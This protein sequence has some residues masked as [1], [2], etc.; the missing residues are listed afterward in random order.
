M[1]KK[2]A[3]LL[4]ITE[5]RLAQ[6]GE[7]LRLARLRRRLTGKQVAERA[8]MTPVTLR[9]LERGNS[10]VTMG[11]YLAV[12]QV[13][14]IEQDLD[15]LGKED[16]R[17]RALQDA[18]LPRGGAKP[19]PGHSKAI[20]AAPRRQRAAGAL[21]EAWKPGGDFVSTS[22]LAALIAPPESPKRRSEK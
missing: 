20:D 6:L 21:P 4:P 16:P 1:A 11:A 5:R 9:N 7:R 12:M 17:G 8:G 3:P 14:G 18:T 13:L 19:P 22:D 2:V 10:G 15:L